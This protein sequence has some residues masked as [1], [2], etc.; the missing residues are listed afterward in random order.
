MCCL[1]CAADMQTHAILRLAAVTAGALAVMP[2]GATAQTARP[3]LDSHR[4]S[5][6]HLVMTKDVTDELGALADS[7]DVET[8]RCL[9][10]IKRGKGVVADLVWNPTGVSDRS[11]GDQVWRCP[12]ATVA[13]WRNHPVGPDERP[14]QACKLSRAEI[15]DA[16]RP[17]SPAIQIVQ[18]TSR[19]A[20]W[21][22]HAQI[23]LRTDSTTLQSLPG[24]RRGDPADTPRTPC[25]GAVARGNHCA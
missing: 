6:V 16:M 12:L 25:N 14:A 9:V 18:V 8:V 23:E 22:T 21:W 15:R 2:R 11:S 5:A 17:R 13:L 10:G 4:P 7:L 20:C 3:L 1:S 19:V 24:Q